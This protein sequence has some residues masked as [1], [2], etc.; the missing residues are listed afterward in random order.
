MTVAI[1]ALVTVG[2]WGI[3]HTGWQEVP[4]PKQVARRLGRAEVGVVQRS[5]AALDRQL[6]HWKSGSYPWDEVYNLRR[7]APAS[8]AMPAH[9]FEK[10]SRGRTADGRTAEE[11]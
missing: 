1:M 9:G 6:Q 2:F 10:M 5:S 3:G 7:V 11:R 4:V 8:L